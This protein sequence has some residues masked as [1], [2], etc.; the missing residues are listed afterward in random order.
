MGL[1]TSTYISGLTASWP[2]SGDL[3][4]QGDDHIRLIKSVLQATFPVASKPFYFPTAEVIAGTQVLDATDQNNTQ[5]VDT[6]GGNVA[7]TLPAGLA[8]GDKGWKIDV[9]KT[10]TDTNAVIVSPSSGTIGSKCGATATIRVGIVCEPATFTW[11]G[12]AWI[13]SKPGPMIGSTENFDGATVPPGYLLDDGS[14]FSNTAFAELFAVMGSS[15]LRDK[16]GRVEAGVD[17]GQNRLTA[18]YFGTAAILGALGGGENFTMALVNLIQ[19]LHAVFLND[20][21]H[22]HTLGSPATVASTPGPL[23]M[24]AASNFNVTSPAVLSNT[25]GITVRDTTGGGGVANQTATTGSASPTPMRTVQP[26][27]IVQ[28]I[29]RAC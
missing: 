24:G 20:P 26:T 22:G 14:A 23:G 4:A 5:M 18:S 15:T 6:S 11:T 19:H 2:V 16:R 27:I 9:V 25:T 10:T 28:K 17:G 1:E 12:A 3:K 21:G 13:C 29:K 8:A 7:V